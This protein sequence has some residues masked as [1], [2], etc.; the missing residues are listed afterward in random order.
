MCE[1]YEGN[2][3]YMLYLFF[4]PSLFLIFRLEYVFYLSGNSKQ[5]VHSMINAVRRPYKSKSGNLFWKSQKPKA[6]KFRRIYEG[7]KRVY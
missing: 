6:S 4:F 2:D 5:E 1:W 7:E 3:A